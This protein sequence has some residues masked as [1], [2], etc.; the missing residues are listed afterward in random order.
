MNPDTKQFE[1]ET[2]ETPPHW[3]RYHVGQRF[4]LDG[5]PF[6]IH[7]ITKREIRLRPCPKGTRQEPDK[8]VDK[9]KAPLSRGLRKKL[10]KVRK[11]YREASDG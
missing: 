3:K 7:R 11:E 8:K 9:P 10:Q 4:L 2:P 6:Q 1:L 5:E